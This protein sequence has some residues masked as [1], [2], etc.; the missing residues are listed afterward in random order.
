MLYRPSGRDSARLGLA[1]AKKRLKRAVDRNRIKRL[2]RE[3]FRQQRDRLKGL[4]I[5]VLVKPGI[6]KADNRTLLDALRRHWRHLSRDT[7]P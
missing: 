6:E 1:V 2:I 3:S 7:R 5:V 4:D